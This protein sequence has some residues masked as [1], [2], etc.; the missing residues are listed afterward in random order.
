MSNLMQRVKMPNILYDSYTI[1]FYILL[2]IN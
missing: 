1:F 2:K